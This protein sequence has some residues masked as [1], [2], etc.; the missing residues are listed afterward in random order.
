MSNR[1]H[2]FLPC[3]PKNH[4]AIYSIRNKLNA[5]EY[6]GSTMNLRRR[7]K[8]HRKKLAN[9]IHENKLLQSDFN[10]FNNNFFEVVILKSYNNISEKKITEA[11]QEEIDARNKTLLYN[12]NIN[13]IRAVHSINQPVLIL[14]MNGKIKF[15][16]N[17]FRKARS[18]LGIANATSYTGRIYSS[19]ILKTRFFIV[20]EKF[21]DNN[22]L[23]I[24][25]L[26]DKKS[27]NAII[28]E[29]DNKKYR[30]ASPSPLAKIAKVNLQQLKSTIYWMRRKKLD[31][32]YLKKANHTITL[33]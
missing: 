21:F 13:A 33:I 22:P 26:V 18:F 17:S 20:T 19:S 9:G 32:Y 23:E 12:I 16:F 11:E 14:S 30:E 28:L 10:Y 7:L 2:F 8:E 4:P 24:K 29:K 15:K 3:E 31:T 25:K 5:K 1:K 27:Y 6:I